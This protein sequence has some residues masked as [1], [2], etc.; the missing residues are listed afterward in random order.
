MPKT[1]VDADGV[2]AN[3]PEREVDSVCP[4]CGVGCQLT[5]RTT[6]DRIVAGAGRDG[7]GNRER[8]CVKGRFGFDYVHHADRLTV[9][10][11]RRDGVPKHDVE[12]D[13]AHPFTHFRETTWEE[14]L[15]RAAQGLRRIRD[16]HGGEALAGFGSAK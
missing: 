11:I 14:A 2:F 6:N 12:I 5:Y 13:P 15:D 9:P 3:A 10:L 1:L 8:L 16:A 4:Y 7:P